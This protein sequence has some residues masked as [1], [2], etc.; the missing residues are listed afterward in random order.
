MYKYT[1]IFGVYEL[2]VLKIRVIILIINRMVLSWTFYHI[3]FNLLSYQFIM[4]D[5]I[6]HLCSYHLYFFIIMLKN[7]GNGTIRSAGIETIFIKGLKR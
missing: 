3:P 7:E 4:I 5:W 6:K 1:D 2:W